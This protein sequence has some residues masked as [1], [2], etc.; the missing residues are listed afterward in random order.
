MISRQVVWVL[1]GPGA[2]KSTLVRALLGFPTRLEGRWTVGSQCAAAG[3]Y[4]GG[5]KDGPDSLPYSNDLLEDV[6]IKDA[7]KRTVL[8]LDGERFA[9]AW[10]VGAAPALPRIGLV[11][12]APVREL[13]TRRTQR[14]S[15]SM[16]DA[17]VQRA[18]DRA[19]RF[20]RYLPRYHVLSGTRY[21]NERQARQLLGLV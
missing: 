15:P 12:D 11:L 2:G 13:Q 1:G 10:A 18:V 8:L 20:A 17:W 6:L 4:T 9:Q 7:P 14:G 19:Y 21:E 3:P 16:P 5:T